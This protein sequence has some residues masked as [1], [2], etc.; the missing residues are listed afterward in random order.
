MTVLDQFIEMI[1]DIGTPLI[2]VAALVVSVWSVFFRTRRRDFEVLLD[3]SD[4]E[5]AKREAATQDLRLQIRE[6][7]AKREARTRE[8]TRQLH[9]EAAECKARTRDLMRQLQKEASERE[10]RWRDLMRQIKEE[11]AERRAANERLVDLSDRRFFSQMEQLNDQLK[12]LA[13]VSERVARNE[14]AVEA[15]KA[16]G[17]RTV[18]AQGPTPDVSEAAAREVAQEDLPE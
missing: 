10:A 17:Y 8:L 18:A 12:H 15:L 5:A 1:G 7:A 4:K 2:A 16:D 3:R 11:S 9:K 14:T 13:D 6:E